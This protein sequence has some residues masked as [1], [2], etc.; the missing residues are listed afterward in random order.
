V[1][2]KEPESLRRKVDIFKTRS[3]DLLNSK[4]LQE[5]ERQ[6]I[7]ILQSLDTKYQNLLIVVEGQRDA[8]VLRNLG[9][10]APII[11]TQSRL[12]RLE[13]AEKIAVKVGKEGQVL[14]LTDFDKEGKE[15]AKQIEQE[16][17][18]IGVKVLKQERRKIRKN[19]G[20]WRCI[21]ELVALFKRSDSPEASR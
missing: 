16:L 10:K 4:K 21:E 3:K 15:I 13:T 5:N 2:D 14:L 12:S 19:M 1:S 17:Q 9:V 20:S 8:L 6:L 11:K 7:E 18:A